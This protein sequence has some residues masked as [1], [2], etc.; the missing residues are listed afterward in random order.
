MFGEIASNNRYK[1]ERAGS[2]DATDP[3][4]LHLPLLGSYKECCI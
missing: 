2:I 1:K 4:N 3:K